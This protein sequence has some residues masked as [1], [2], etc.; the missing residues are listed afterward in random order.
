MASEVLKN[1]AHTPIPDGIIITGCFVYSIPMLVSILLLFTMR[2][3]FNQRGKRTPLLFL[4]AVTIVSL[5]R[6]I[7]LAALKNR[8]RKV[9]YLLNRA[10]LSLLL[11]AFSVVL[12]AW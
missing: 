5:L 7:W 8:W 2:K 9:D 10:A 12:M 1:S 3:E 11:T 4:I 6:L